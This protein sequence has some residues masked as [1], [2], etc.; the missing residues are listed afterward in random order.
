MC[1]CVC[2]CKG[3]CRKKIKKSEFHIFGW[4]PGLQNLDV[5]EENLLCSKF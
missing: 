5:F 1:V 4:F 2:V 3:M